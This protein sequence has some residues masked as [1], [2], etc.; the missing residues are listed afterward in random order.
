[1]K[2][3]LKTNADSRARSISAVDLFCGVG[4]LTKGLEKSGIRVKLG[5]D[6]DL[7]CEYPFTANNSADFLLKPVED[8]SA[9]ELDDAFGESG[10][11]LLAGCAPCQTFSTYNQ[12]AKPSDRRW[13]LL[14][15]FG[16]LVRELQ[17]DLVTMENV[18]R[19][20]KQDVFT[21]FV[22]ALKENG[23]FVSHEIVNCADYG[24]PQTRE[25]LVL[26]ASRFGPIRMLSPAE[27]RRKKVTVRDAIGD[28]PPL[29]AGQ[30][31]DKDRLHVC[32]ILS[33][34]NMK[35]IRTSKP[36]GT[37]RDWDKELVADC[38][39]KKTGKTY[40]SVY[41]RMSW[42]EPS[43][44]ITTQFYGFGN[45][46]FGHPQQHRAISLREGAILQSFPKG[47]KFT[48]PR[49]PVYIKT[50]GRLIGNA[51]PVKLAAVIGKSIVKH[52]ENVDT[53]I[54]N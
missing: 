8:L 54:V 10:I 47:Y 26:L 37:W 45:G 40:P 51:V 15:Q 27:A 44:T 6:T 35:R 7:A 2:T 28:L 19:L 36:G 43:P 38:H 17:P 21:E 20:L 39:K 23:Y 41:G 3:S 48:G 25:R 52:L 33:E 14:L 34:L 24:V 11:R 31:N 5:I 42:D 18:P 12:K 32:S 49:E 50:I 16:R 22:D 9:D 1:M 46:R 53:D 13:W 29:K 30:S 4:G